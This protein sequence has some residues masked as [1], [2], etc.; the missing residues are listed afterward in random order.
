[1]IKRSV[2]TKAPDQLITRESL[3]ITQEDY[4]SFCGISKSM[5]SMIEINERY[6]PLGKHNHSWIAVDFNEVEKNPSDILAFEKA[7][8]WEIK[9]YKLYALK[10]SIEI[11]K[12][13]NLLEEM[14]FKYKAA[15][16]R[17]K[18]CLKLRLRFTNPD[19][20]EV[21]LLNLWEQTAKVD[22]RKYKPLNQ[23]LIRLKLENLNA[24]KLLVEDWLK[25]NQT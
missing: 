3:G 5:L 15:S 7:E 24:K 6:W 25:E 8:D 19:S 12:A 10:L 2:Y 1:M 20:V 22:L 14:E 4:A 16:M 9:E 21:S 18:T 13:E 17:M 11:Y 23:Q